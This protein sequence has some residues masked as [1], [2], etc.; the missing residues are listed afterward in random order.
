MSATP[1]YVSPTHRF[2][3]TPMGLLWV[4]KEGAWGKLRR[5]E[6]VSPRNVTAR[7][8]RAPDRCS[9]CP[10]PLYFDAKDDPP[11]HEDLFDDTRLER[12]GQTFLQAIAL[13]VKL[14]MVEPELV[15]DRRVPILH[16]DLVLDSSKA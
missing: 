8:K 10:C 4:G 14:V 1:I 7:A 11:L 16:R 9:F 3:N 6:L 2:G 12:R 13:V 5:E 15:E